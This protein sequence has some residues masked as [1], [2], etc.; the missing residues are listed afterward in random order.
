EWSLCKRPAP[1]GPCGAGRRPSLR[2]AGSGGRP[3]RRTARAGRRAGDHLRRS[4]CGR[5]ATRPCR[6]PQPRLRA[7]APV[8]PRSGHGAL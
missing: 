7:G 6:G 2:E 5:A 1:A 3:A 8:R 4:R